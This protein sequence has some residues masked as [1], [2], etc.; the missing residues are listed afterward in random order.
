MI[1]FVG[2]CWKFLLIHLV[3]PLSSLL[4]LCHFWLLFCSISFPT[5]Y[6]VILYPATS[7]PLISLSPHAADIFDHA[8][9]LSC[10]LRCLGL[11][12]FFFLPLSNLH[13]LCREGLN[14][15][16][17]EKSKP[18]YDTLFLKATAKERVH[19]IP[20]QRF[21]FNCLLCVSQK[22]FTK[23]IYI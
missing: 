16:T 18:S 13:H 10:L 15:G 2:L 23:Y 3:H 21:A 22:P 20:P 7:T 5:L 12:F 14:C 17:E 1:L 19:Q 11:C 4:F 9:Q 8:A 6:S